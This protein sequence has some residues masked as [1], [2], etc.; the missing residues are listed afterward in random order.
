[1][2]Y[3]HDYGNPHIYLR[4][5]DRF[6]KPWGKPRNGG[7]SQ[8]RG[9]A[10]HR[11]GALAKAPAKGGDSRR[12]EA[13]RVSCILHI[14]SWHYC[15]LML[16]IC[17]ILCPKN[18]HSRE[19]LFLYRVQVSRPGHHVGFTSPDRKKKSHDVWRIESRDFQ[20]PEV[21]LQ[22][23]RGDLDDL[24]FTERLMWVSKY[25]GYTLS[26]VRWVT[27][28][29]DDLIWWSSQFSLKNVSAI[30]I[31]N[32]MIW[33]RQ[34][35]KHVIL[36]SC[37]AEH[38]DLGGLFIWR[39]LD[40]TTIWWILTDKHEK[41]QTAMAC[42][43][44][45]SGSLQGC[46]EVQT[47]NR[48]RV[49]VSVGTSNAALEEGSKSCGMPHHQGKLVG[50]LVGRPVNA[51]FLSDGIP[52]GTDGF[53]WHFSPSRSAIGVWSGRQL[54]LA[55]SRDATFWILRRKIVSCY[56]KIGY[57]VRDMLGVL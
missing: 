11:H 12:L 45:G 10:L 13:S 8:R 14:M 4:N 37:P 48:Q 2:G 52:K 43:F 5:G 32:P 31:D 56:K 23:R 24:M 55:H 44:P 38:R 6:E 28:H 7:F 25:I 16:Y 15:I 26:I 53:C 3:P 20:S 41:L 50:L 46:T 33:R 57:V 9:P 35:H 17:W 27:I 47:S 21:G 18:V 36:L 34:W 51:R 39:H 54:A 30:D 49:P 19:M 40:K 1:M 22:N 42:I 29:L